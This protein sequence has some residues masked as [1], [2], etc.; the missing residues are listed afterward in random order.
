MVPPSPTMTSSQN[1]APP[2]ASFQTMVPPLPIRTSSQT[3]APPRASSQ[4]MVLPSP[5]VTNSQTLA[6][7]RASSQTMV[8]PSTTVTPRSSPHTPVSPLSTLTGSQTV[9]PPRTSSHTA[10]LPLPM[11]TGS[12]TVGP[13]RG[14]SQTMVPP[15]QAGYGTSG[16]SSSVSARQPSINSLGNHHARGGFRA[17]PPHLQSYRPTSMPDANRIS[18]QQAPNSIPGIPSVPNHPRSTVPTYISDSHNRVHRPVIL[19]AREPSVVS[20]QPGTNAM[21]RGSNVALPEVSNF[22][23]DSVVRDNSAHQPTSS[24]VVCLSDDE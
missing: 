18:T 17:T 7:S 13:P 20:S 19:P 8:P 21:L 1:M 3:M 2:R 23:A 5:I 14:S 9:A 15:L 10:V 11:M 22:S 4:T 12:Q 6:P 16:I 24:D